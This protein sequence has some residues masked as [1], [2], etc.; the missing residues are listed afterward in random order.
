M[1]GI[2]TGNNVSEEKRREKKRELDRRAQRASRARNKT[3][4]ANLEAT[5]ERMQCGQ[6]DNSAIDLMNQLD[7]TIKE[8][9]QLASTLASV[10]SIL[11]RCIPSSGQAATQWHDTL[12]YDNN[13]E[14]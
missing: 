13:L 1:S 12:S 9:D 10:K 8:R 5:I 4:I 6:V 11:A 2:S 7:D 3:R 14:T